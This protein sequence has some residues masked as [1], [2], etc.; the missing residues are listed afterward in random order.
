MFI[1]N[2][3]ILWIDDLFIT[4]NK[5]EQPFHH[6]TSP[7]KWTLS[8]N[9][10]LPKCSKD[11]ALKYYL[12]ESDIS[13][14]F[15]LRLSD[16]KY[17]KHL[18][19]INEETLRPEHIQSF[20]LSPGIDSTSNKFVKTVAVTCQSPLDIKCKHSSCIRVCCLPNQRNCRAFRSVKKVH[21]RFKS[22]K[23]IT[24]IHGHPKCDSEG[25][26]NFIIQNYSSY[27]SLDSGLMPKLIIDTQ[28]SV[29]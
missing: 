12:S 10:F 23:N 15:L 2:S 5:G 4:Y 8:K 11:K 13:A 7:I 18:F 3:A 21:D 25:K 9:S 22:S 17:D 16:F 27:E 24:I 29:V 14:T 28:Q 6:S 19:T 20:C 26:S 1:F